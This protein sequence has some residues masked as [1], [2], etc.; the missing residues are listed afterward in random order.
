MNASAPH[1]RPSRPRALRL[2]LVLWLFL[3]LSACAPLDTPRAP[4]ELDVHPATLRADGS[5]AVTI[6]YYV[7]RE[8]LVSLALRAADGAADGET[9]ILRDRAPRS[10]GTYAFRFQGAVAGR[11]LPNGQYEVVATSS[12]PT[13]GEPI[14]RRRPLTIIDADTAPPALDD[15]RVTPA[16]LTPNQDGVDDRLTVTF[17]AAEPVTVDARLLAGNEVRWLARESAAGPGAARLSWPPPLPHAPLLNRAVDRLPAGPAQVEIAVQDRA[18]NRTVVRREITLGES[19]TPRARLTDVKIAPAAPRAGG[20]LTITATLTNT[21]AV[22]LRAAPVGPDDYAWRENAHTLGYAAAPGAVRW[23]VDY[24]LNRSGVAYPFRW[25]LG[26]DL[27]P[28]ESAPVSGT[29]RLNDAFPGEP[30][31]LWAGVIHEHNR[32][33]ADKRGV[34]RVQRANAAE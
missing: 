25:S 15:L 26:R 31:H 12:D 8:S 29:I 13:G 32:I 28:G 16:A 5:G 24:S 14:E 11:V 18:G 19:G 21:G 33:L 6:R 22:T 34:T 7:A 27:A 20:A 1:R 17:T 23:G 2:A 3:A 4:L 10:P 9:F 30:V